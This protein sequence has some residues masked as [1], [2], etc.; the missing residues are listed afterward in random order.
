MWKFSIVTVLILSGC[1][2]FTFNKQMCEQIASEPN[3]VIPKEC[4]VYSEE[5]AKKA[6]ENTKNKTQTSKE[7][8]IEFN[9]NNKED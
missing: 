7:D 6:F 4:M 2:H 1:S 3:A 9:K 8:I 5:D